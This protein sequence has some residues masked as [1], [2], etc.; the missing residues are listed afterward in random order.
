MRHIE[1]TGSATKE[2]VPDKI[3]FHL[4]LKEY[5]QDRQK[6]TIDQLE[7]QLQKAVRGA[8]LDADRLRVDDVRG[9]RRWVR[10]KPEEEFYASKQ[11]RL[12]LNTLDKINDILNGLDERAVERTDVAEVDHSRIEAYR[13]EVK[14]AAVKAAREKAGYL[15]AAIDEEVGPVLEI[16]EIDGGYRP[17]PRY[18]NRMMMA[19]AD[20]GSAPPVGFRTIELRYEVRARFTIR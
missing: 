6:V 11:Y 16:Q 15:L 12:E 9:Y 18:A 20:G 13:R 8:G 7:A 17:T 19:E 3:Y 10:N 5:Q 4:T 2:I 14:I 1:V